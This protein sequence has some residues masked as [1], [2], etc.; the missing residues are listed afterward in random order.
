VRFT[1]RHFH[2]ALVPPLPLPQ[3]FGR[4]CALRI[5]EISK[6]GAKQ[7]ELPKD[8]GLASLANLDKLR[9]V[10]VTGGEAWCVARA[11]S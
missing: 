7:P 9:C 11:A 10:A 4:A 2:T 8:A 1:T 6:P 3:V 5:A